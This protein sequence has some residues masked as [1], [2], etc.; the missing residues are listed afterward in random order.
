MREGRRRMRAY[1]KIAQKSFRN[2]LVF[3]AEYFAALLNT[4]VTILVNLAIWR[5]IYEEEGG[6]DNLQFSLIV[7]YVILALAL[8]QIFTMDEYVIE[9]K[10]KS[11]LITS[12][13]LKPL[14]FRLHL[15][16]FHFGALLYRIVLLLIPTLLLYSLVYRVLP[17][18]SIEMFLCFLL[19]V[20]LG[21]FVMYSLNFIVWLS[22]FWFYKT[23][24]LVT[25]K[26]TAVLVLSGAVIPLWFMPQQ[27]VHFIKLTPFDTIFFI[28]ISIY[29]GQIPMDQLLF[30]LLRQVIWIT[31]L[32]LIGHVL[33]KLATRRLIVQGG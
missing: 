13:L 21:Y 10:I 6:L 20:I 12:D 33:W 31:V 4:I 16:S 7:T 15:F 23:F 29:L 32:G 24:S 1:L 9:K 25:I 14:S 19:S 26:D 17:P 28:P 22:A 2:N 3:R 18:F 8:F 11:G 30:S 5:A 27:L